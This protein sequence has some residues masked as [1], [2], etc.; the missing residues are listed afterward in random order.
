MLGTTNKKD[1]KSEYPIDEISIDYRAE[2][3]QIESLSKDRAEENTYIADYRTT[4]EENDCELVENLNHHI[5]VVDDKDLLNPDDT[6]KE[7][8][9]IHKPNYR[10]AVIMLLVTLIGVCFFS[11]IIN[12]K[13]AVMASEYNKT[14]DTY[15]EITAPIV[16]SNINSFSNPSE[17]NVDSANEISLLYLILNQG[18]NHYKTYD[19]NG[20]M[21][22][23][24]DDVKKSATEIFGPSFSLTSKNPEKSSFYTFT[25]GDN[26]YHVSE[27]TDKDMYIP[28]IINQSISGDTI[29]L[30]VGYVSPDDPYRTDKLNNPTPNIS[31]YMNYTLKLNSD[32][33]KYYV[34]SINNIS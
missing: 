30:K 4:I 7:L 17:I 18:E 24:A 11:S 10:V 2:N 19:S 25:S 20:N 5:P 33:G 13:V 32:T 34:G 1:K 15:N 26:L 21:I 9:Y 12:S 14:Y 8:D 16:M 23:P 28:Y 22:I 6:D 29:T 27:I 3:P 31:K